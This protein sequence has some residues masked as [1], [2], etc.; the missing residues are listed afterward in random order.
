MYYS[1]KQK[2][3]KNVSVNQE[4][5]SFL[6]FNL[7]QIYIEEFHGEKKRKYK[8]KMGA[9]INNVRQNW[10]DN[11]F[12]LVKMYQFGTRV[13]ENMNGKTYLLDHKIYAISIRGI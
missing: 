3:W 8:S 12:N 1:Y 6:P 9:R 13:V 2:K 11:E 4:K 10:K 5:H 7:Q